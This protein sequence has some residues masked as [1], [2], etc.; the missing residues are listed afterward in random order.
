MQS[1]SLILK[2]FFFT[3][4]QMLWAL[5]PLSR[6]FFFFWLMAT[7]N[8]LIVLSLSGSL[9]NI[10]KKKF[11][12]K[13]S[14]WHPWHKNVWSACCHCAVR[15]AIPGR[16]CGWR[17]RLSVCGATEDQWLECTP[18]CLGGAG[19]SWELSTMTLPLR[20]LKSTCS[21]VCEEAVS[22]HAIF[23]SYNSCKH[24]CSRSLKTF[25]NWCL[26]WDVICVPE[27]LTDHDWLLYCVFSMFDFLLMID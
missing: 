16:H 1:K 15:Q 12:F 25:C 24:V 20:I 6:A 19:I 17:G 5:V 4:Q 14:L 7:I 13:S 9:V 11:V 8:K 26:L 21:F 10:E 23:A 2:G 22:C 18:L 3:R 27:A